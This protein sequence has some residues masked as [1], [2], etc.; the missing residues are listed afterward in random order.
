MEII[1]ATALISIN[2][3]FFI[4]L[5]S[6]L[7]FLYIMNRVMIRPLVNT[8]AERNEYFD[9]IN[10]DVTS[11][12]SDLE[13]L[14]KD[15]DFQRSQVLKEAHGEVGKLDEEAEHYAA[16]IIASARSEITKLSIET[17]ARV[18]KQLKDIRSQLEGEVE[19]LTTLIMEKVLHR[20]LQ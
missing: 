1:S 9:G 18:D 8:M 13:N 16:E 19:A 7:V 10:S 6:F 12:Q 11:A 3:T 4:Q 2:E 5:I 20:R 14:H 17:E 15:L